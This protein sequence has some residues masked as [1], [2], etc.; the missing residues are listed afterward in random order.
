PATATWT[1]CSGRACW[2]ATGCP[3][4]ADCETPA[5]GRSSRQRAIWGGNVKRLALV[6][7]VGLVA[8]VAGGG[9]AVAA[10]AP[11]ATTGKAASVTQSTA[12]INGTVNPHGVPTAFYF[13]FGK[14]KSYGTRTNT[15]DA[16]AGTSGRAVSAALTGLAANT[17]YHYRRV[18]F[19]AAGTTR[20]RD[21]TFKTPQ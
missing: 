7:A 3:A 1:A 4:A 13:E 19:S 12:T 8:L 5:G 14:T 20:G 9:K 15:G 6:S 17:T 18:A 2:T 21:R 11:A 10:T 16:G